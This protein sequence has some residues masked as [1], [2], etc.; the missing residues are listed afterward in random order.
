L[1]QRCK[2]SRAARQERH[3]RRCHFGQQALGRRRTGHLRLIVKELVRAH[4]AAPTIF[5]Q[6]QPFDQ[7]AL[8]FLPVFAVGQSAG[9]GEVG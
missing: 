4:T 1:A 7:E 9:G 5:D 6:A 3:L 8:F 2:R